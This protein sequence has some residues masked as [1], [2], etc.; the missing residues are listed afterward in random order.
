MRIDVDDFKDGF[1]QRFSVQIVHITL[2]RVL[3]VAGGLRPLQQPPE[4]GCN[5]VRINE[6]V[7][8]ISAMV[9]LC[10]LLSLWL[11]CIR[12]SP[13]ASDHALPGLVV[14]IL[15]LEADA[16]NRIFFRTR[17]VFHVGGGDEG[18][19]RQE[20]QARIAAVVISRTVLVQ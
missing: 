14:N 10:Q 16:D 2:L 11:V 6:L 12:L 13:P 7:R 20:F 18:A 4:N 8:T 15:E 1:S 9:V 19:V 3:R 17:P 5:P